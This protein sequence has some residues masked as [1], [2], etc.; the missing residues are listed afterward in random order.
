MPR[1]FVF[2]RLR[3]CR[4][5]IPGRVGLALCARRARHFADT[6]TIPR[7]HVLAQVLGRSMFGECSYKEG[8][9]GRLLQ[10]NS[11]PWGEALT[12]LSLGCSLTNLLRPGYHSIC[13]A[14]KNVCV[15]VC[16]CVCKLQPQYSASHAQHLLESGVVPMHSKTCVCVCVCK[17]QP[18]YS[19]SHA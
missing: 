15:C 7:A 17:F 12:A 4:L 10:G 9:W 6:G 1:A 16:V 14:L 13:W 18:Q 2:L 5:V 11:L 8:G 19:A 3:R